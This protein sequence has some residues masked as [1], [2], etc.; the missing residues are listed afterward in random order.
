VL[1][2]GVGVAFAFAEAISGSL[3]PTTIMVEDDGGDL[4][5]LQIES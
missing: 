4:S 1:A 5:Q 3:V 2:A